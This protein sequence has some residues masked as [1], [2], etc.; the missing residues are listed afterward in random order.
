MIM[1]PCEFLDILS[2]LQDKA[3]S[4]PLLQQLAVLPTVI[5]T[6]DSA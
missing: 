3:F 2:K 4:Y 1:L 6:G 5:V